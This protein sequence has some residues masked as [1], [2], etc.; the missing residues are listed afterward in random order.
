[1]CPFRFLRRGRDISCCLHWYSSL[2]L[3][4]TKNAQK[5]KVRRNYG[6]VTKPVSE[7][8]LFGDQHQVRQSY[9]CIFQV[10]VESISLPVSTGDMETGGK[11]RTGFS[12]ALRHLASPVVGG[13][14]SSHLKF[15]SSFSFR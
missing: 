9:S 14:L 4:E 1:M 3:E 11:G 12:T 8:K 10:L 15:E 7:G 5:P 6:L 13:F 2:S